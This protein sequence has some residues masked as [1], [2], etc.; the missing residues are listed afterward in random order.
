M[1]HDQSG[2]FRVFLRMSQMKN[3]ETLKER[4]AFT[5]VPNGTAERTMMLHRLSPWILIDL[6]I[7][8]YE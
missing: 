4:V 3:T 5:T 6:H 1:S 8:N 7:R 2:E